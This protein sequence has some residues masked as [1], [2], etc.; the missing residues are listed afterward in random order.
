VKAVKTMN[1]HHGNT[2]CALG[3]VMYSYKQQQQQ[4]KTDNE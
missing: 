1:M 2:V 3:T 4:Q